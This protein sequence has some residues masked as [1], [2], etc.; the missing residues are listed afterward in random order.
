MQRSDTTSELQRL[1]ERELAQGLRYTF[2][3]VAN[4]SRPDAEKIQIFDRFRFVVIATN[5]SVIPVREL[6]GVVARTDLTEFA[7]V[8]VELDRLD[9]GASRTI[10]TIETRIVR[11]PGETF[12]REQ[13]GVISASAFADLSAIEFTEW[14]KP[15]VPSRAAELCRPIQRRREPAVDR[16][17]LRHQIWGETIPLDRYRR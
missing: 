7:P 2:E 13:I 14:D 15:I 3:V 16:E 17:T 12:L 8:S 10:A 6:R 9:N 5:T 1:V 11:E 4:L